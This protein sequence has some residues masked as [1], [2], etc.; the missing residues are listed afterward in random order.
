MKITIDT[1]DLAAVLKETRGRCFKP[2]EHNEKH[3]FDLALGVFALALP[4]HERQ[5]FLNQAD[6]RQ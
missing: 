3:C 5:H 1:D 6:Y 4:K 2:K